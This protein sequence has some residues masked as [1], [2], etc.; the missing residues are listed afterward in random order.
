MEE[1]GKGRRRRRRWRRMRMRKRKRR[2][3]RSRRRRRN[4]SRRMM[5]LPLVIFPAF[6]PY[7]L[8]SVV[9]YNA[10]HWELSM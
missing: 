9:R 4:G 6:S 2:R 1:A 8:L 7:F 10:L 3:R 5:E